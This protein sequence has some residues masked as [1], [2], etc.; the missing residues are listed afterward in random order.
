MSHDELIKQL[1]AAKSAYNKAAVRMV[2]TDGGCNPNPGNGAWAW[3]EV[4]EKGQ[5]VAELNG[6]ENASTNNR[7]E[8]TAV[9]EFIRT[10]KEGEKVR[11]HSDS[12][13]VVN[14]V[15]T[16][17]KNW[18]KYTKGM[19]VSEMILK[20]KDLLNADLF[21]ELH[22]LIEAL[23]LDI[24]MVWVRGHNGDKHNE[25]CDVICTDVI[26]KGASRQ[27]QG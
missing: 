7:M 1:L 16:W 23:A 12:Q 19:S 27:K 2:W 6:F 3:V 11:I 8:I 4:N 22:Y 15:N 5:V 26:E 25:Y 18:F 20:K 9:L 21:R 14:A 24:E 10:L 17:R 13:Y